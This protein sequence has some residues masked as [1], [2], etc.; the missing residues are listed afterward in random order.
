MGPNMPAR[1][2]TSGEYLQ[3]SGRVGRRGLDDKGL[4]MLMVGEKMSPAVGKK[5]F[6]N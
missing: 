2:F 4:V 1:T 6:K 3:M 5:S